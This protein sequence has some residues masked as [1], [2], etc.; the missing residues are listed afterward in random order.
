MEL[1][2]I[3]SSALTRLFGFLII[4]TILG[5]ALYL[6]SPI[7]GEWFVLLMAFALFI[8]WK[9]YDRLVGNLTGDLAII[10]R[11][12]MLRSNG[13]VEGLARQV[14]KMAD[15]RYPTAMV[16]TQY[17]VTTWGD[18]VSDPKVRRN[19]SLPNRL[20]V[21][22]GQHNGLPRFVDMVDVGA[23]YI[24]APPRMG[25]TNLIIQMIASMMLG[26]PLVKQTYDFY[27]IDITEDLSLL[28][29]LGKYTSSMK[30][31]QGILVELGY[32]IDKRNALRK[33]YELGGDYWYK[34]PLKERPKPIVLVIDEAIQVL[35]EGGRPLANAWSKIINIG[36]KNGVLLITTTLY[37]R[38]DLI[39][40][41]FTAL[42][43]AKVAGYMGTE[44]AFVNM[45][46]SDYWNKYKDQVNAY[47]SE[48]YRFALCVRPNKPILFQSIG[49][50]PE[51]VIE[52]VQ[53]SV[54]NPDDYMEVALTIFWN[55]RGDIS[56]SELGHQTR[57]FVEKNG[58]GKVRAETIHKKSM[59]D[60][61]RH[62]VLAGILTHNG[63]REKYSID[64]SVTS[65]GELLAKWTKY[66]LE[67]NLNKRVLTG[68]EMAEMFRVK[69]TV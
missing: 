59:L 64:P 1:I 37:T 10:V 57:L 65:Y 52:L 2:R 36:H 60:L 41:E 28:A 62:A 34:I 32:E 6:F 23:M 53:E 12:V 9:V 35:K 27:F 8:S 63:M 58:T 11:L 38:S 61:M 7:G 44:Q 33:R 42:M 5:S 67:G 3:I 14:K 39:P 31:A 49:I 18:A 56:S 13:L 69:E 16:E 25:K 43:R 47:V 26:H 21:L 40:T 55:K 46:D 68:T 20:N 17:A 50:P 19:L 66:V 29:P 24:S 54:V 4:F 48:K 15:L 22:I 51:R 30:E 45:L